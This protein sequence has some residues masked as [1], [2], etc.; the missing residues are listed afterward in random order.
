[1]ETKIAKTEVTSEVTT[2]PICFDSINNSFQFSCGH[3]FC[4]E[5]V[6]S[7]A[8]P[9]CPD[10]KC[11]LIMNDLLFIEKVY[12]SGHITETF[13][14][15]ET[16]FYIK[17][18]KQ[19]YKCRQYSTPCEND[20]AICEHCKA[21]VCGKCLRAPHNGSCFSQIIKER[22]QIFDAM[23][24]TPFQVCF[25]CLAPMEKKEGCDHMN[26]PDCGIEQCFKCGENWHFL[27]PIKPCREL[28]RPAKFETFRAY[29]EYYIA[30]S[31]LFQHKKLMLNFI[32]NAY[33]GFANGYLRNDFTDMLQNVINTF[34]LWIEIFPLHQPSTMTA[35]IFNS[36][37]VN[38]T[39]TFVKQ[40]TIHQ[41]CLE[42]ENPEN[43]V[44][45]NNL[46][47]DI[48]V[49]EKIRHAIEKSKLI[50]EFTKF[51]TQLQKTII[52]R[53][54]ILPWLKEHFVEI[55]EIGE[56]APIFSKFL[57]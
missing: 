12:Q 20:S 30:Y 38:F 52:H 50:P 47:T 6:Q 37:V 45:V 24:E 51:V 14:N 13:I 54:D 34:G 1:M 36:A 26:C 56:F 32:A 15:F 53:N 4:S 57:L 55:I 22:K 35:T 40:A 21:D 8:K 46:I 41:L 49:K 43:K 2:C 42:A 25:S 17:Q 10:P 18:N 39:S 48:L 31:W 29:G 16:N 44:R 9:Q 23:S 33:T 19:C 5:C 11:K 7:Y 3:T 27:H 28:R